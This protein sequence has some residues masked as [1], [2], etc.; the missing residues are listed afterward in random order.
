MALSTNYKR[1]GRKQ[2]LIIQIQLCL[3]RKHKMELKAIILS[4]LKYHRK[5]VEEL[6]KILRT[7]NK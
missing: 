7:L 5:S 6:L 4:T 1:L 2:D 3:A